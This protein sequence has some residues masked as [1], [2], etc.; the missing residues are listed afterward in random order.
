MSR[1]I[2]KGV[3][4]SKK[5]QK[6]VVISVEMPKMHK[7]YHKRIRNTMKFKA[8]DELDVKVGDLVAIEETKPFSKTVSW[9][10]IKKL[11]NEETK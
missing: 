1:K 6:T 10:V 8:R 2:I 9:K 11:S 4:T 5:M 3:V 7:I